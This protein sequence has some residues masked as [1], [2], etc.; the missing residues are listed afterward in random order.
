M[1]QKTIE[2]IEKKIGY[3]FR[4][5]ILLEQAFTRS[6]YA[7]EH[8]GV[9][10]NEV[11]EFIGDEA[12]DYAV[13]KELVGTYQQSKNK[14]GYFRPW[15]TEGDLTETKEGYVDSAALAK[16]IDRLGL[17]SYLQ[18]GKGDTLNHVET[19]QSVKEDLFEAIIGAVALDSDWDPR[20]IYVAVR[21]MESGVTD[22][23]STGLYFREETLWEY[24]QKKAAYLTACE[25]NK[26]GNELAR[27]KE[28]V[29]YL[30]GRMQDEA[31]QDY[32]DVLDQAESKKPNEEIVL[33]KRPIDYVGKLQAYVQTLRK[34]LP[35]YTFT[36]QLIDGVLMFACVCEFDFGQGPV[37]FA[38]SAASQKNARQGAAQKG[39]IYLR[40][41]LQNTLGLDLDEIQYANEEDEGKKIVAEATEE[42]AVSALNHLYQIRLPRQ[43]IYTF[44]SEKDPQGVLIWTC[45]CALSEREKFTAKSS[46]KNA[47]KRKAAL[48]A[49]N[50]VPELWSDPNF[51]LG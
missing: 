42:N 13:A 26:S 40:D 34:D 43:P 45:T 18:M 16:C 36:H 24:N 25:E 35:N 2:T 11:L 1:D 48:L 4:N 12:L 17:S 7:H 5:E 29:D 6:S 30:W 9:C 33:T 44:V 14:A 23:F 31:E 27:M 37:S 41:Y 50:K 8:D 10:D 20:S 19:Q 28:E 49:V 39:Y 51:L 21:V 38:F 47:A 46:N 32:D 3:I 22:L 15:F